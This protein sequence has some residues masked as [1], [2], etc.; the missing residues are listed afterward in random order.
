MD[1]Q[2]LKNELINDSK[3]LGYAGKTS[4]QIADLINTIGLSNET[5]SRGAIPSYEIISALVYAELE[6]LNEKETLQLQLIVAG[7]QVNVDDP[8]IKTIFAGLF[9]QGAESRDNLLAL[10]TRPAS[11]AEALDLGFVYKWNIEKA[12]LL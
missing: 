12:Q 4:Q 3:N 10:A 9:A 8:K 1:F 5:V 2:V 11:R 6:T 7:G